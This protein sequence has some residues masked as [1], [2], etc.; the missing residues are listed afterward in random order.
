MANNFPELTRAQNRWL[1][2]SPYLRN[3]YIEMDE[4]VDLLMVM[5]T[6]VTGKN[7]QHVFSTAIR[8]CSIIPRYQWNQATQNEQ[9]QIMDNYLNQ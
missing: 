3:V 8:V 6:W 7:P 5:G 2:D 9:R 4:Y 1:E